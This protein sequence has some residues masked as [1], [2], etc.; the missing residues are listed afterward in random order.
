MKTV[1]ITGRKVLS[2]FACFL[3]E[4]NGKRQ[5][6]EEAPRGSRD[7]TRVKKKNRKK[8]QFKLEK[9]QNYIAREGGMCTIL[10]QREDEKTLRR[11]RKKVP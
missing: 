11:N 6:G 8:L 9:E 2:Q 7:E 3:E 10:C 4:E 1:L 5:L